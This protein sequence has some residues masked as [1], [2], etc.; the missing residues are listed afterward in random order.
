MRRSCNERLRKALYHWCRVSAQ[1]DERSKAHYAELRAK[2]HTHGRALRGIGDRLMAV[3][4][5]ML[6]TRT[7]YDPAFPSQA[8]KQHAIGKTA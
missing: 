1:C 4:I 6:K 8:N 7:L 3:L 5:S 2:G